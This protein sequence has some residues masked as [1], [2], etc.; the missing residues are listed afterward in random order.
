M[1]DTML[2]A[3][4]E[5]GRIDAK[6]YLEMHIEQGRCSSHESVRR[7]RTRN[8]GL[9]RNMVRFVGQAAHS[10]RTPMQCAGTRSGRCG[11]GTGMP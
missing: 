7:S 8:F 5:L 9:E 3:R 10:G 1:L 2:I 11:N 6:A 4:Q